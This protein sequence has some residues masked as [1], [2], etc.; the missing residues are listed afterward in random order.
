MESRKFSN[1]QARSVFVSWM[2]HS[3]RRAR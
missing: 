1:N 2:V 3:D